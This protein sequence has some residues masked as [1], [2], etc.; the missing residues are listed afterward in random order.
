MAAPV[1]AALSGIRGEDVGEVAEWR[2]AAERLAPYP[3]VKTTNGMV[4][5]DVAGAPP[6]EYNIPVP[7]SPV[8]WGDHVGLDS[9]PE[10]LALAWRTLEQIRVWEPHCGYLDACIRPRLGLLRKGAPLSPENFL[11]SYQSLRLFPAIPPDADVAMENFAAE[12]GF[13]VSSRCQKGEIESVR[14][15]SVLGEV[16]QVAHPWPGRRVEVTVPGADKVVSAEGTECNIV[17][18]TRPRLTY[19][20][21]PER[22]TGQQVPQR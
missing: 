5:V 4:W 7:L 1:S 17:C 10:T 16:C 9:P 18:S 19:L 3:M 20:L 14:I 12:G 2:A 21:N 8:F 11:Q 22:A 15:R 13:R 6:I